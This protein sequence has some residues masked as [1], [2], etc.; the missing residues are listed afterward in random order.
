MRFAVR[1]T[2]KHYEAKWWLEDEANHIFRFEL[3]E[4]TVTAWRLAIRKLPDNLSLDKQ[5]FLGCQFFYDADA[6][7]QRITF[8]RLLMALGRE[9][10]E[11][12]PA[13]EILEDHPEMAK[14]TS[15]WPYRLWL[16]LNEDNETLDTEVESNRWK[17]ILEEKYQ[18]NPSNTSWVA[19]LVSHYDVLR[20]VA[21]LQKKQSPQKAQSLG[22]NY[23]ALVKA[24]L[25][26]LDITLQNARAI[27]TD[28][29]TT[30]ALNT[31]RRS[32]EKYS[33]RLRALLIENE[34]LDL[35]ERREHLDLILAQRMTDSDRWALLMDILVDL[36]EDAQ[37]YSENSE[38]METIASLMAQYYLNRYDLNWAISIWV[39]VNKTRKD[40][41]LCIL[42]YFYRLRPYSVALFLVILTVCSF[43]PVIASCVAYVVL[44]LLFLFFGFGLVAI[45]V[46]FFKKKGFSYLELFLPRLLG[47]IVVGLS[48]LALESTVWE[49]TL[50]M[51]WGNWLLTIF[52]SYLGSLAYLFLDV[53]KNTRLL[54]DKLDSE[55]TEEKKTRLTLMGR[56]IQ[57]T[58]RIFAIGLLEAF[59]FTTIVSALIPFNALGETFRSWI[60]EGI[61]LV[62]WGGLVLK[63]LQ[64]NGLP[65]QVF[66]LQ[67]FGTDGLTL[68]YFPKLIMLWTGLS[69]L[70]GAFVQLLWQ[71]RQITAS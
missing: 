36:K 24:I 15:Q 54:P 67:L 66:I 23:A 64:E 6:I 55:G 46:R 5:S 42:L 44:S 12:F 31:I 8:C 13:L 41:I 35:N 37:E 62:D 16:F 30:D 63:V 18:S 19:D 34:T 4:N 57:T 45:G 20:E 49:I 59:V 65:A 51:D 7:L 69:L 9:R 50:D 47:S 27:S 32:F 25:G 40:K 11:I 39:E 61:T 71:D 1:S 48:I 68:A 10:G 14:L 38:V 60:E 53:H 17:L 2:E 33:P 29:S 56:S 43:V 3:D 70:T 22:R 28:S 21:Y 26:F 58:F 52:A